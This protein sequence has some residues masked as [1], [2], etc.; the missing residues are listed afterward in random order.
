MGFLKTLASILEIV[1]NW[2]EPHDARSVSALRAAGGAIVHLANALEKSIDE[3][4][5]SPNSV[6]RRGVEIGWKGS[7]DSPRTRVH[8]KMDD[9]KIHITSA[10]AA[11]LKESVKQLIA[12]RLAK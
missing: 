2:F 5:I 6:D 12:A 9:A 8:L 7:L 1:R 3:W 11:M 4:V 10:E